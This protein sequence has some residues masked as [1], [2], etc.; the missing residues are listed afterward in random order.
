MRIGIDIDDVMNDFISY[1]IPELN[2]ATWK[3][4]SLSDVDFWHLNQIRWIS[5]D[6]L[7]V[8]YRESDI[9]K[10][11]PLINDAVS[12]VKSLIS[13]GNRV[14]F[15]TSR[16][17]FPGY[18]TRGITQSVFND[19]AL[20][21]LEI[22]IWMD[23]GALANKLDLDYFLDDA[24]YNVLNVMNKSNG[25]QWVLIRKNWNGHKELNRLCEEWFDTSK[26]DNINIVESVSEFSQYVLWW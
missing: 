25:T 4:Y 1:I 3:E 24:L 23:K 6:E 14:V 12:S 10:K 17:Q 9:Y 26:Y 5:F 20:D 22:Y 19:V 7:K 18:D 8:I 13:A 16:F 11:V 15:I 2:K 21:N